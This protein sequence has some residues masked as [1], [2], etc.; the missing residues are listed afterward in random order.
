M[1]GRKA[2]EK[3][4]NTAAALH[5]V[6]GKAGEAVANA[7]IAPVR[8]QIDTDCTRCANGKCKKH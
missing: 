2:A 3:L 8:R 6:G 1:F 7:V 5:K 4:D